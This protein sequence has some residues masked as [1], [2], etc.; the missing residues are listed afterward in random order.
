M[1]EQIR[2][3]ISTILV[4]A[5]IILFIVGIFFLTEA[6]WGYWSIGPYG[7]DKPACW[8]TAAIL[9]GI[10]LAL[11]VVQGIFFQDNNTKKKK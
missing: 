10:A 7:V 5:I 9:F 3:T 1:K 2:R 4:I 8:T 11:L 6:V